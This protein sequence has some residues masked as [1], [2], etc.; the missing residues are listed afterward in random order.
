MRTYTGTHITLFLTCD[1]IF[2]CAI[3]KRPLNFTFLEKKSLISLLDDYK[4]IVEDKWTDK[5]T[6]KTK[7]AW[8]E[9]TDRF[10][11][12]ADVNKRT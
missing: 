12:E 3:A 9:I 2:Q 5:R 6:K 4:H 8:T 7:R 10:N 1:I 11:A